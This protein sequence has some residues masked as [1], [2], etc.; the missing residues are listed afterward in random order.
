LDTTTLL[1][2][3]S[4]GGRG[5]RRTAVLKLDDESFSVRA[6]LFEDDEHSVLQIRAW[7]DSIGHYQHVYVDTATGG[8]LAVTTGTQDGDAFER[9]KQELIRRGIEL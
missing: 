2:D 6:K 1:A 3:G 8:V 4:N 7:L 5:N 9:G